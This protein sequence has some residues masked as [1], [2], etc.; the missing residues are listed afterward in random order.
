MCVPA[1]HGESTAARLPDVA[2]VTLRKVTLRLIPVSRFSLHRRVARSGERRVRGAADE[3]RS[4]I[5][6]GCVWFRFRRVFP[7]LLPV[8]S[9]E[10]SRFTPRWRAA[11]DLTNHDQLGRHLDGD[12]VC[13]DRAHF[14]CVAV[15]A[16]RCGGGFLSRCG[17]LLES[18]VSGGTTRARNLGIHDS[19]SGERRYR[20]PAVR[21]AFNPEW[22]VR[23]CWMAVA[24]FGGRI[25]RN[26]ASALS[27]S[28][29]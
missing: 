19:C 14:L 26:F 1:G 10:Q 8:R 9:P 4:W 29:I 7:R 11:L 28:S 13:S 27:C 25:S 17:L 15:S 20:R 3:F 6:F 22:I 24:F 5:Q 23:A 16:R 2:S 18:L 21:R 12:D